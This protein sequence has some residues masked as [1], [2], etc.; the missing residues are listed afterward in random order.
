L[1]DKVLKI[2]KQSYLAAILAVLFA[3][4]VASAQSQPVPS[5]S[6][7][8]QSPDNL[9]DVTKDYQARSQE[10]VRIQEAEVNKAT[11][12]LEELRQLVAEGLVAKVE[13]EESEQVLATLGK[14]LEATRKEIAD[15]DRK[16]ALIRAQ[17]E[18]AKTQPSP[19]KAP[20]KPLGSSLIRP[21]LLRYNGVGGWSLG[22]LNGI[23][24]FFVQQFGQSLPTS[25]VGQSATHNRLGYDHRNAVDV[26]LHPN[27]AQG[28]ALINYLQTQGIPFLA[29]RSAVPG[30]ATGPHIHIGN[31][32][33]RI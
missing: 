11:A 15:S 14:Q 7:H 13:L 19:I 32:S 5:G 4:G 12:K 8:T 24:S 23:Q 27:S 10:L 22:S 29:F 25:A 28:K 2:P 18:L 31:P 3:C 6:E 1:V 21:T 33:H 30:V 20:A 9:V 17:Q 16:I 26:A